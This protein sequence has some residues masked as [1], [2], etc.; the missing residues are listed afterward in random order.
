MPVRHSSAQLLTGTLN[1]P[2]LSPPPLVVEGVELG[3]GLLS[4]SPGQGI[5]LKGLVW[6]GHGFLRR[7]AS[8]SE[9]EV[10]PGRGTPS[11]LSP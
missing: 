4:L 5:G 10:G 2:S 11:A 9:T 8:G 6:A 7:T 1:R 3:G